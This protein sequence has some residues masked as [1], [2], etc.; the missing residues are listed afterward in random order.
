[1]IRPVIAAAFIGAGVSLVAAPAA[2]AQPPPYDCSGS[3]GPQCTLQDVIANYTS[4]PEQFLNG[5]AAQPGEIAKGVQNWV[6]FPGQ[7]VQA[8]TH[9]FTRFPSSSTPALSTPKH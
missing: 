1:M 4:T 8:W 2:S 6:A 5:F 9:P 3:P 7:V